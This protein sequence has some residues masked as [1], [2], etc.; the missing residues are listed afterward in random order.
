MDRKTARR[1]AQAVTSDDAVARALDRPVLLDRYRP[2]LN[3]RWAEGCHEAAALHAEITQ[4][5]YRG[6]LRTLSTASCSR[7]AGAAPPAPHPRPP[8]KDGEGH[9]L[10]TAPGPR[11]LSPP[12]TSRML[13]EITAPA[14]HSPIAWPEHVTKTSPR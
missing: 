7:C 14:A 2:H 12:T 10:A 8:P 3:R 1:F 6:S 4:L 9:Q 5:G 13:A 11:D